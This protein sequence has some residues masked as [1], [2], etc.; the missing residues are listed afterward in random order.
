MRYIGRVRT[1]I[2]VA[3]RDSLTKS[4][5]LCTKLTKTRW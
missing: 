1:E 3:L 4:K 5:N 2:N